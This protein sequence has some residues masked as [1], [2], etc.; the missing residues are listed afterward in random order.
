[1]EDD[2]AM[3]TACRAGAPAV[4]AALE[5]APGEVRLERTPLSQCLMPASTPGDLQEV[6]GAYVAVAAD[7]AFEA[8]ADP[9]GP[10]AT[11]LGYLIGAVRRGAD[12]TQ[13]IHA[14]LVRRMEQELV[15]VDTRS[16][17]FREG[18]RAGREAG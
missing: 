12:R 1:M 18:E 9:D 10:A 8:R 15:I 2:P 6:G 3:P 7:L 16:P 5:H 14:E 11:R 13:G 4:R 17:A